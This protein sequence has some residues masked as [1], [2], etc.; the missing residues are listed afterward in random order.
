MLTKIHIIF[1]TNL[2]LLLKRH[3]ADDTWTPVYVHSEEEIRE[4]YGTEELLAEYGNAYTAVK[5]LW[6]ENG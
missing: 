2:V 1:L 5:D 6:V 3:I 4:R